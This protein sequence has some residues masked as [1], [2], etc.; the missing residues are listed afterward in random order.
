[1]TCKAG[2]NQKQLRRAI[3][4]GGVEVF[5]GQFGITQFLQEERIVALCSLA[6]NSF[7]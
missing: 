4:D 3:L 2:S 5:S 1:M 7:Q 6:R